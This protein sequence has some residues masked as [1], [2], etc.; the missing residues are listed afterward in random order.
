MRLPVC[1][2]LVGVFCYAGFTQGA[3][4][5]RTAQRSDEL[6]RSGGDPSTLNQGELRD[7]AILIDPTNPKHRKEYG[8]DDHLIRIYRTDPNVV[9]IV[10]NGPISNRVDIV[11]LGDGYTSA[12]QTTFATDV[13]NISSDFF[14]EPPFD[15]Y[16]SYFN[17]HRVEVI[18]NESGVDVRD[19][20]IYKDTA[21]DMW[22]QGGGVTR[23]GIN[24]GKARDAAAFAP[25]Q[26]TILALANS[27][28]YGGTAYYGQ[29]GMSPGHHGSSSEI[30][31]HEFGHSYGN[32]GDEYITHYGDTWTGR[33]QW[34]ANLSIYEATEM[35]NLQTKWYRWL[36]HPDV[37]T[38]E[39][40]GYYSYGIYRSHVSTK[41][42]TNYS[43]YREVNTEQFIRM[44]YTSV[45]PIDDATAESAT[46]YL[47]GTSFF[48]TPMQPLGLTWTF[49]GIST[50]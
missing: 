7:C 33:E 34:Q 10:N 38:V 26:D 50:R 24:L 14:L 42:R 1:I 43:P 20:G 12:E 4:P 21:L 18:S 35:T 47:A 41:M 48:V 39:G 8:L 45:D 9:T 37:S 13:D 44:I 28:L 11:Y 22:Y 5:E 27:S 25:D 3:P 31:L 6:R 36:D 17:V 40:G 2:L 15:T 19:D 29:L 49:N 46:T 16:A 23:M 30:N 32:L